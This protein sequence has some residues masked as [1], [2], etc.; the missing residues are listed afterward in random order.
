[1]LRKLELKVPP[2]IVALLIAAAL[3][4]AAKWLPFV[5]LPLGL[6]MNVDTKVAALL[7]AVL[8]FLGACFD[9]AALLLFVRKRTAI[10]P[11]KP[12]NAS[13]LV[14]S[15][16]YRITRNPMYLG[17]LCF[18]SAWAVYL[19]SV[20]VLIGPIIFVVYINY[21]QII[22]EERLLLS[23]FGDAYAGYAKRVRRWL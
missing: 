21:F 3:W 23:K 7:A 16:V 10:N 14:V 20:F 19:N 12:Q 22:P 5:S 13:V 8:A 4:Q 6:D 1:M 17:L 11:L 2:P 9:A 18:L 15:G